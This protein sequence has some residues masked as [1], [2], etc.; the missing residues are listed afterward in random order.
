MGK[1]D[2]NGHVQQLLHVSHYQRVFHIAPIEPPWLPSIATRHRADPSCVRGHGKLR[3]QTQRLL[4]LLRFLTSVYSRDHRKWPCLIRLGKLLEIDSPWFM[5]CICLHSSDM[6]Y[7]LPRSVFLRF[8]TWRITVNFIS[9]ANL[10][11][12]YLL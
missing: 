11:H 1:L 3:K 12:V 10:I 7:I 8:T 2:I 4:P 5:V 6:V 9:I